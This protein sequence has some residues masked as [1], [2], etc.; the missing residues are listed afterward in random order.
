M[1]K[2]FSLLSIDPKFGC[3]CPMRSWFWFFDVKLCQT[4]DAYEVVAVTGNIM[5]EKN[6]SIFWGR[7]KATK[8]WM[9]LIRGI[10]LW[11][12]SKWWIMS[13]GG[14]GCGQYGWVQ[15]GPIILFLPLIKELQYESKHLWWL[16]PY[17]NQVVCFWP[18]VWLA[19]NFIEI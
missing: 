1:Q 8:D 7:Q 18:R 13:V 14:N 3:N 11:K 6:L 2:V 15:V 5:T 10:M 19:P 17:Q 12:H 4:S 16:Y 9:K